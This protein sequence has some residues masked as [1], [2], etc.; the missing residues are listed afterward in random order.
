MNVLKN[1][2]TKTCTETKSCRCV[3]RNSL[4]V[5]LMGKINCYNASVMK[6]LYNE[7]MVILPKPLFKPFHR[8]DSDDY[9][10]F[11]L[12]KPA[13]YTS[14][15]NIIGHHQQLPFEEGQMTHNRQRS[16]HT[17][18]INPFWYVNKV[19]TCYITDP[20]TYQDPLSHDYLTQA[21]LNISWE[22]LN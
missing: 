22:T 14:L 15:R 18:N 13:N 12:C 8:V 3:W 2:R 6:L 1:N 16:S 11:L 17:S 5:S 19:E 4:N 10:T 20:P 7:H 21:C 9:D